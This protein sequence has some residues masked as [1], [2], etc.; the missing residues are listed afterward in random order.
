[1]SSRLIQPRNA[2]AALFIF[3]VSGI[4]FCGYRYAIHDPQWLGIGLMLTVV[5]GGQLSLAVL[6]GGPPSPGCWS[7]VIGSFRRRKIL[8]AGRHS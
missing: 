3:V 2:K 1:M 5:I 4:G 7:R 6:S 8:K